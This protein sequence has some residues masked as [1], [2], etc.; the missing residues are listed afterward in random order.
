MAFRELSEREIERLSAEE[1]EAYQRELEKYQERRRVLQRIEELAQLRLQAMRAAMPKLRPIPQ[2][3]NTAWVRL[4]FPFEAPEQKPGEF[5]KKLADAAVLKDAYQMQPYR[6]PKYEKK[7][8]A[9]PALRSKYVAALRVTPTFQKRVAAANPLKQ[10]YQAEKPARPFFRKRL[11]LAKT[12]RGKYVC[13]VVAK[14]KI[15]KRIAFA[16]ALRG[17]YTLVKRPVQPFTVPKAVGRLR[18]SFAAPKRNPAAF[19]KKRA[20]AVSL[21]KNGLEARQPVPDYHKKKAT[22][23]VLRG[24]FAPP[25]TAF[26]IARKKTV[27]AAVLKQIFRSERKQI[28]IPLQVRMPEGIADM[29]DRV[30]A[31]GE[32][33]APAQHVPSFHKRTVSALRLYGKYCAP[34]RLLPE[35]PEVLFADA[36]QPVCNMA[37]QTPTPPQIPDKAVPVPTVREDFAERSTAV[38]AKILRS[39]QA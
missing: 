11:A 32:V 7:I 37:Y 19:E 25:L 1:R 14:P 5:R 23:P 26:P 35:K 22:A 31:A 33:P 30:K 13:P 12:L 36:P 18:G 21:K 10:T 17:R 34:E 38:L 8:A 6:A 39:L 15:V 24:R 16:P 2:L 29:C 28:T 27:Q 3:A 4:H 9:A 20:E